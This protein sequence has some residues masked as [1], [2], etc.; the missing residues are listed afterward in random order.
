MAKVGW[1]WRMQPRKRVGFQAA[2]G[3]LSHQGFL[4]PGG[5]VIHGVIPGESFKLLTL[6]Q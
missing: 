1:R 6:H 3:F 2:K 4:G 5:M